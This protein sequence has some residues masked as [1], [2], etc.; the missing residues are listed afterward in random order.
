MAGSG[1]GSVHPVEEDPAW[2]RRSEQERVV[3]AQPTSTEVEA[4]PDEPAPE[5]LGIPKPRHA[6]EGCNGCVLYHLVDSSTAFQRS[7]ANGRE[8]GPVL[9]EEPA[10]GLAVATPRPLH[11]FAFTVAAVEGLHRHPNSR[12]RV[13]PGYPQTRR[14]GMRIGLVTRPVI[15]EN[16]RGSTPA[17]CEHRERC[18]CPGPEPVY[19]GRDFESPELLFVRALDADA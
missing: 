19:L 16:S 1:M 12:M 11:E 14:S 9:L 4:D 2:E 7:A 8:H 5:A 17:T 13:P 18:S 15:I 6:Q 3:G 10:E